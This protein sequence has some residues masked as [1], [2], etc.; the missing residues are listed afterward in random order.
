[1]DFESFAELTC[2]LNMQEDRDT[3]RNLG[4]PSAHKGSRRWA[5]HE[6]EEAVPNDETSA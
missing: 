6:A 1:M 3:V 5:V 4:P 2:T